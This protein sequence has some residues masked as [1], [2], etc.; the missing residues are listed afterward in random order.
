MLFVFVLI[1]FVFFRGQGHNLPVSWS[2][3]QATYVWVSNEYIQAESFRA[4]GHD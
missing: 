4:G 1:S 2:H 3:V